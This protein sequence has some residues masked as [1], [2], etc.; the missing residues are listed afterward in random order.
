V[1]SSDLVNLI[2]RLVN[3]GHEDLGYKILLTMPRP[4][5]SDGELGFVGSFFV[6]QLVNANRVS[7][8]KKIH[9]ILHLV[10]CGN[11]DLGYK[12]VCTIPWPSQTDGELGFVTLFF[13]HQHEH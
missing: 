9:L 4:S 8:D 12:I 1:C 3:C 6:R 2:L 13:I 10:N 7:R 11:E 5:R